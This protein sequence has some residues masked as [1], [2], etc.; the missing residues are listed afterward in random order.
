MFI[1]FLI[2]I[3]RSRVFC[4]GTLVSK[5]HGDVLG[6][7]GHR[8]KETKEFIKK[9]IDGIIL[10]GEIVS[11]F[12]QQIPRILYIIVFALMLYNII[13]YS[14]GCTNEYDELLEE[15][16]K[17]EKEDKS[18]LKILKERRRSCGELNPKILHINGY[19]ETSIVA[20]MC[21]IMLERSLRRE[22]CNKKRRAC[23]RRKKVGSRIYRVILLAWLV[24]HLD[25]SI[26]LL[27]YAAE[28]IGLDINFSR[29][30]ETDIDT[31]EFSEESS[32]PQAAETTAPEQSSTDNVL[33]T[34]AETKAIA[35][36]IEWSQN[37][38]LAD[39]AA[40]HTISERLEEEVF[41]P[42]GVE[43]ESWLSQKFVY[44]DDTGS[45]EEDTS[46]ADPHSGIPAPGYL[47]ELEETFLKDSDRA[48]RAGSEAEWKRLAPRSEI[49]DLIIDGRE[50]IAEASP[51]SSI[52]WLLANDH[53]RYALEYQI[54]NGDGRTILYYYCKS[55]QSIYRAMR[56]IKN[57]ESKKQKMYQYLKAR[58]QDIADQAKIGSFYREKA[59]A[60]AEVMD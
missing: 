35:E 1:K 36:D 47:S 43:V 5:E 19:S 34:E 56:Y 27:S 40:V 16:N 42:D 18:T 12:V 17:K 46:K 8:F 32:T 31:M 50:K 45:E 6:M 23:K 7:D 60:I 28:H 11:I 44:S 26:W 15:N 33:P 54:Q 13:R 22:K 24:F 4:D 9:N 30:E 20:D 25:H 48:K 2:G 10:S 59:Q 21:V 49:L 3:Y 39:P 38:I 37:F 29:E 14:K 53:Q 52:Y 57:D 58:Y 55:I 41:Y 51:T